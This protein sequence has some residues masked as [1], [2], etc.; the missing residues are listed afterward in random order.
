MQSFNYLHGRILQKGKGNFINRIIKNFIFLS[1]RDKMKKAISFILIFCVVLAVMFVASCGSTARKTVSTTVMPDGS[2]QEFDKD[3]K[4]IKHT[5]YRDDGSLDC[6]LEYDENSNLIKDVH[7]DEKGQGLWYS[8][9]KYDKSGNRIENL[10]YSD[11]QLR[12]SQ[13]Y[14]YDE[15]GKCIKGMQ[16]DADGNLENYSLPEYNDKGK[17][18]KWQTYEKD[19]TPTDFII[20]EYD[21][22]GTQASKK[23]YS[24]NGRV[25]RSEI[26]IDGV[27]DRYITYNYENNRLFGVS[28]YDKNN[29]LIRYYSYG[30]SYDS[31]GALTGY[32]V[33][34][35]EPIE[36]SPYYTFKHI[37][38]SQYDADGNLT[39]YKVFEYD[40]NGIVK[41]TTRYNPDGTIKNDT[42]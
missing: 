34:E 40:E 15:S 12:W 30:Y 16:Y 22:N 36:K 39:E 29:N 6:I 25:V 17:I 9:Y 33:D 5:L 14:E 2:L 24:A 18:L 19:N 21:E 26:Y 28:E 31:T 38:T 20:Y 4:L 7:Y 11:G 35:L 37:K 13:K 10:Y 1:R 27:Y 8:E 42:Y 41:K 3:G 32:S 23:F